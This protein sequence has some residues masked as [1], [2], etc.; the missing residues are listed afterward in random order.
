MNVNPKKIANVVYASRMGNG[1]QASGDGWKHRGRGYIQ[2]TGKNNYTKFGE[3]VGMDVDEVIEYL[4]TV[5]GALESACWSFS[6][7]E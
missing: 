1:G 3:A 6:E 7:K 5:E 2:L 4:D